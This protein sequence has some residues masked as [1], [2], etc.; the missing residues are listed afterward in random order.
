MI[1]CLFF[2]V[3]WNLLFYSFF[4]RLILHFIFSCTAVYGTLPLKCQLTIVNIIILWHSQFVVCHFL[5]VP[6]SFV[7]VKKWET[8]FSVCIRFPGHGPESRSR[9]HLLHILFFISLQQTVF[10]RFLASYCSVLR[11]KVKRYTILSLIRYVLCV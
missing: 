5:N 11:S 7:F 6:F 10:L 2:F 4:I 1:F 3:K 9:G 8:V